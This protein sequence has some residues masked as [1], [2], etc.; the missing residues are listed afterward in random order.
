MEGAVSSSVIHRGNGDIEAI[1]ARSMAEN[2]RIAYK[3]G[4][5]RFEQYC[6]A[7]Q[8]AALPASINTVL[9]YLAHIGSR[10]AGKNGKL[11]S[12][13]TIVINVSAINK[14]HKLL[15]HSSPAENAQVKLLLSGLKKMR[16]TPPRKVM[17]LQAEH[18]KSMLKCCTDNLTGTRNAAI[19]ALG[20]SAA[21]RRSEIIGLR[22]EDVK[23]IS[24]R[25][26]P[27]GIIVTIRKSKTDQ[28]GKGQDIA[29]PYGKNLRTIERLQKWI[30]QAGI[31]GGYLF[32]TVSKCGSKGNPLHHSDI[33]RIV[34]YYAE[35][36]GLPAANV[37]GHSLRAGFVTSAVKNNARLDKIMEVTR[38]KNPATLFQYIRDREVFSNHAGQDFL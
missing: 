26:K 6:G 12:L 30:E 31:T 11:L 2:T 25:N 36:I 21:L 37:A 15:G 28:E 5:Q 29:I 22:L 1:I 33:P 38:H 32:T 34:K 20:F 27:K 9:E 23:F 17:A 8:L 13:G 4:W 18:L 16:A 7:R 10:P 24:E 19:L 14:V 3:K 35:K